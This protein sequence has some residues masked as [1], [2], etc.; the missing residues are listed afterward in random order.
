M[1]ETEKEID[2]ELPDVSE[3]TPKATAPK[4]HIGGSTCESCEG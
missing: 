2:F 4:I 1:S 3:D